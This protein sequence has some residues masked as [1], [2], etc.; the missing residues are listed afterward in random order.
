MEIKQSLFDNLCA[1]AGFGDLKPDDRSGDIPL[2]RQAIWYVMRE[3]GVKFKEI[4]EQSHR[5]H[6]TVGSGVKRF[7]GFLSINDE[8]AKRIY[9]KLNNQN[10]SKL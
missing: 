5:T 6:G 9:K 1:S 8:K 4:S 2:H 7:K 3:Q 10:K